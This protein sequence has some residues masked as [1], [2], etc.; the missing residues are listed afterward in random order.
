ML[1]VYNILNLLCF[2]CCCLLISLISV[3]Y[4]QTHTHTHA[5]A[6]KHVHVKLICTHWNSPL[7]SLSFFLL[8]SGFYLSNG[9]Y[10]MHFNFACLCFFCRCCCQ[11]CVFQQKQKFTHGSCTY[12]HTHTRIRTHICMYEWLGFSLAPLHSS[13]SFWGHLLWLAPSANFMYTWSAW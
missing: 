6:C 1:R 13:L 7:L 9:I 10:K 11:N 12:T 5:D 2:S 4:T 3:Q 8:L